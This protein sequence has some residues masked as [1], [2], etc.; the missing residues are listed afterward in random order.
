MR[1]GWKGRGAAVL[2]KPRDFCSVLMAK[3]LIFLSHM[4]DCA[5]LGSVWETFDPAFE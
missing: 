2:W 5:E 1:M 4:L 3:P